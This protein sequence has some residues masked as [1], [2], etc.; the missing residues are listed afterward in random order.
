MGGL[1]LA[2]PG[3]EK[4]KFVIHPAERRLIEYLRTLRYGV[5]E[6]RIHQGLPFEIE[7]AIEKI[8]LVDKD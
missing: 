7:K 8:R 4:D 2:K 3:E 5:V 6:V 1:A